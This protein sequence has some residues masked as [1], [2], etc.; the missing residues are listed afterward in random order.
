MSNPLC[1]QCGKVSFANRNDA[2]RVAQKWSNKTYW[3]EA[4]RA[5]HTA[6]S[7]SWTRVDRRRK[8]KPPRRQKR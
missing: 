6:T 7:G 2:R 4:C 8:K 1:P 3:S 5:W